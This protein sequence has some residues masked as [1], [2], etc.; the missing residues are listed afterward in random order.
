MFFL[1]LSYGETPIPVLFAFLIRM[2]N[3]FHD[4]SGCRCRAMQVQLITKNKIQLKHFYRKI[5]FYA[6]V[7]A[8][9]FLNTQS[10][11]FG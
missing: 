10:N 4:F 2:K 3:M 1:V 7:I 6:G 9:Q 8:D 11:L 5:V